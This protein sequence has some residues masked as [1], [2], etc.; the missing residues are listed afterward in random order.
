MASNVSVDS[1][2]IKGGMMITKMSMEKLT[3]LSRRILQNYQDIGSGGW[4]DQKYKDLGVLVGQ[5]V[6]ALRKPMAELA[7]CEEK[8]RLLLKEVEEYENTRI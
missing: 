5:S 7:E 2:A 8:L 6:D 1:K 4:N 3:N